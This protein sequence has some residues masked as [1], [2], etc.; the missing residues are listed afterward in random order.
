[1]HLFFLTRISISYI[2]WLL[3]SNSFYILLVKEKVSCRI[4]YDL[5]LVT[6]WY[7]EEIVSVLCGYLE[8]IVE[9]ECIWTDFQTMTNRTIWKQYCIEITLD[10]TRVFQAD[11]AFLFKIIR[12][13]MDW[14]YW[15]DL[16]AYINYELRYDKIIFI[17]MI[18]NCRPKNI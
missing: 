15:F 10:K 8:S 2:N 4:T 11:I 18:K 5:L 7:V 16:S 6:V 1:M 12:F 14:Y 9:E 13:N 17:I 3:L